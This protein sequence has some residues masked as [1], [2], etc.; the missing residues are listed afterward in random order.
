MNKKVI[1][2]IMI[3]IRQYLRGKLNETVYKTAKESGLRPEVI[4]K[5]EDNEIKGTAESL[6]RYIDSF[7]SR[8]PQE[9]YR[10]FY[11]VLIIITQKDIFDDI[12]G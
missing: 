8:F 10:I 2:K 1:E 4:K 5:L 3:A 6:C 9:S 7:C 11:N 12:K